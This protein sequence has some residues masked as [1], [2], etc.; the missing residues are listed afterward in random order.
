VQR[1]PDRSQPRRIGHRA[2]PVTKRRAAFRPTNA[3]SATPLDNR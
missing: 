3:A 1:P 2:S